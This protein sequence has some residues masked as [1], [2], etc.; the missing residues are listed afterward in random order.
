M[1]RREADLDATLGP[2]SRR[3]MYVNLLPAP[4]VPNADNLTGVPAWERRAWAL[5]HER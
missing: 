1:R 5:P 4:A 3:W 2:E